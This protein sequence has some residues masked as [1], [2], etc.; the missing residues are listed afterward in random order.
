LKLGDR[1]VVEIEPTD[2]KLQVHIT[3]VWLASTNVCFATEA[4]H[5]LK[6]DKSAGFGVVLNLTYPVAGRQKRFNYWKGEWLPSPNKCHYSSTELTVLVERFR[7]HQWIS[8]K[9]ITFNNSHIKTY[10]PQSAEKAD[11]ALVVLFALGPTLGVKTARGA[12]LLAE[13]TAK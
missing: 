10:M 5:K 2:T 7:L 8:A 11:A 4:F 6:D 13:L 12:E 3:T 9:H 1:E